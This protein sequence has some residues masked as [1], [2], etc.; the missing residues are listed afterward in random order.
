MSGPAANQ[1]PE[2]H[3]AL[4]NLVAA[5]QAQQSHQPQPL[6]ASTPSQA[7]VQVGWTGMQK[8]IA[9]ALA[10]IGIALGGAS[11]TMLNTGPNEA[12]ITAIV[13]ES[14]L[15]KEDVRLI[16]GEAIEASLAASARSVA[17]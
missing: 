13:Q 15:S 6:S 5:L 17:A 7:T 12:Q 14:A 1:T 8:S 11:G 16:V 4:M 3:A 2:E 10:T 9:G